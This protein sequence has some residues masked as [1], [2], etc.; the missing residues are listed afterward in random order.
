MYITSY[1]NFCKQ[2]LISEEMNTKW[3]TFFRQAADEDWNSISEL[4]PTKPTLFG[5]KKYYSRFHKWRPSIDSRVNSET[6]FENPGT[7]PEANVSPLPISERGH[8]TDSV[9]EDL[10]VS[11]QKFKPLGNTSDKRNVINIPIVE[12]KVS[13]R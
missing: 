10:K 8:D 13:A 11:A 3:R 4:P 5:N 7:T 6:V 12:A 2:E 1:R 9:E